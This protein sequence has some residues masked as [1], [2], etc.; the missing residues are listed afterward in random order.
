MNRLLVPLAGAA[1]LVLAV[2]VRA[3]TAIPTSP[4]FTVNASVSAGCLV[5]GN[6]TQTSGVGFGLLNFGTYPALAT[7]TASATLSAG[8][9]SMAQV[10]CTPGAS[11]VVM[12]DGGQHAS[13]SQRRM[14]YGSNSY[15]PYSLYTSASRTTALVP[16]VGVSVDASSAISLPVYGVATLPGSG[17]PAGQYTDTVQVTF[18]W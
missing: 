15:L 5:T 4:S 6:P 7:G 18:S 13:G 9:G 14:K 16:G 1:A 8:S 10:Q 2:S 11:V 3:T 12:L 17:L